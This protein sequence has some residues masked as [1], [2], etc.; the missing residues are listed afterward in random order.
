M[1]TPPRL[2]HERAEGRHCFWR[3]ACAMCVALVAGGMYTSWTR[4]E[5]DLVLVRRRAVAISPTNG[6]A[7]ATAYQMPAR[8]NVLYVVLEDFGVL[9]SSTFGT[10]GGAPNGTTPHL[11]A[12]SRRGLVFQRAYCNAPICNPSRSS[13]LTGR[14][15]SHTRVFS[16]AD[17]YVTKV[18]A[19]TP[20]LVEFVRGADPSASVAC[21]GGK[22]FHE[23]CDTSPH[24]F[25]LPAVS[26]PVHDDGKS[27]DVHKTEVAVQLLRT[28]ARNHTRFFLAV[29]LSAT[30]IMRPAALCSERAALRGGYRGDESLGAIELHACMHGPMHTYR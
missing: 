18:P 22:I 8:L 1:D 19:G 29:G 30:H 21:A 3:V 6:G 5:W 15:P 28:F 11:E 14:R 2:L 24:G 13:F 26:K 25:S 9:G 10:A 23:A 16:N 4:G 27:N 17:D 20:D 7:R 12:L